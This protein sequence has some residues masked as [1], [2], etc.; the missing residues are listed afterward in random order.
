MRHCGKM[1][2]DIQT[3]LVAAFHLCI[4]S[5]LERTRL[6]LI[7]VCGLVLMRICYNTPQYVPACSPYQ[8]MVQQAA[9]SLPQCLCGSI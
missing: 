5:D 6:C 3:A 9:A 7:E 2:A 1:E 4:A 8:C